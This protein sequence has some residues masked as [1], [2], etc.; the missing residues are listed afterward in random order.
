MT[1]TDLS[2]PWFVVSTKPQKEELVRVLLD[3]AGL[4]VFIPRILE[5]QGARRRMREQVRLLFP[6]YLFV[7]MSV[8]RD[9]PRVRWTP[10]VKKVLGA[11]N[12]PTPIDRSLVEEL[13]ARMGRRGYLVQRPHFE[14]G[15][16]VEVRHG[17]FVGLLGV[18]E[19]CSSAP[20]RVRVLL[21]LFE[22]R[23]SVE[24]DQRNLLRVGNRV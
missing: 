5:W 2:L 19:G 23:T 20:E 21:T 9:Y 18:V 17:P 16:K 7:S 15:D 13:Q 3:Q 22:R 6:G 4:E 1:P 11:D 24:M 14:A 12:Q 10:G 8:L